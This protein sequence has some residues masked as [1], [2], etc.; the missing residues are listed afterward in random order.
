MRLLYSVW[1]KLCT[2][3]VFN[4]VFRLKI[5]KHYQ[6]F[7]LQ[8]KTARIILHS[9]VFVRAQDQN[10]EDRHIQTILNKKAF[11]KLSSRK[12]QCSPTSSISSHCIHRPSLQKLDQNT[13]P[14]A[15][16]TAFEQRFLIG[17]ITFESTAFHHQY[18]PINPG[19]SS[20]SIRVPS[21]I[22]ELLNL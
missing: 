20:F 22:T 2:W 7:Q 1:N 15:D 3:L 9:L 19:K 18:L 6:N 11:M 14:A 21:L 17:S 10:T 4:S 13:W 5:H 8:L 16:T 12:Y